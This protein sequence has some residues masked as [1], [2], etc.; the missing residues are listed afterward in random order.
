MT[1][2]ILKVARNNLMHMNDIKIFVKN[3]KEQETLIQ[4]ESTTKV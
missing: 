3:E 4:S 1:S 2:R